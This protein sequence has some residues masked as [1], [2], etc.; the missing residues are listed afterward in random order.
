MH[1]FDIKV[2]HL[3][4]NQI[5]SMLFILPLVNLHF[6]W[7]VFYRNIQTESER[8]SKS[9]GEGEHQWTGVY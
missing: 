3:F 8:A 5:K 9:E 4:Q 2:R 7:N 6:D 1:I